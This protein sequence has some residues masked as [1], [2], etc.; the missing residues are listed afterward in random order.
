MVA[1][2]YD[3]GMTCKRPLGYSVMHWNGQGVNCAV[4]TLQL[5]VYEGLQ[6]PSIAAL[7][8]A[9][10][11]LVGHFKHS[12]KATAALTQKQKQMNMPIKKLIQDC[13]TRWNSNYNESWR[14]DG[15]YQLMKA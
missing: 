1:V 6:I 5:C 4:H 7:L 14:L 2:V 15:Q 12:S 9:G 13:P 8:A 10:R 11:K 3:Q